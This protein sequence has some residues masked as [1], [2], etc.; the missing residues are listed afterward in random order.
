MADDKDKLVEIRDNAPDWEGLASTLTGTTQGDL[1]TAM[2]GGGIRTSRRR[3]RDG[4]S[5]IRAEVTFLRVP[6]PMKAFVLFAAW[7]EGQ[8]TNEDREEPLP[9]T[10]EERFQIYLMEA[11]GR[12]AEQDDVRPDGEKIYDFEPF[13][14]KSFGQL[15]HDYRLHHREDQIRPALQ[16]Q[17]AQMKQRLVAQLP[18]WDPDRIEIL[19][20]PTGEE[21]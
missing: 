17:R 8:E 9:D 13:L 4:S 21:G 6:I 20:G 2:G 19:L 12:D 1:P 7:E 16:A 10:Q 11:L 15:L 14:G 3:P 18:E 5:P